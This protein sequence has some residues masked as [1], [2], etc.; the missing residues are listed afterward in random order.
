VALH[1]CM[2]DKFYDACKAVLEIEMVKGFVNE[3]AFGWGQ[4][5]T[6]PQLLCG[7]CNGTQMLNVQ[8]FASPLELSLLSSFY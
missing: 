5:T 4:Q 1:A 6:M 7:G 8:N 3:C 2:C